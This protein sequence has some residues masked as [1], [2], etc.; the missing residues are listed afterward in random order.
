ML[1][2]MTQPEKAAEWGICGRRN[3]GWGMSVKAPKPRK[4]SA[5]AEAP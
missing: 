3:K 2:L 5:T 1:L 4:Q